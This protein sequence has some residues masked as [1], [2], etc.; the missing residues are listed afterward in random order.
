[1]QGV[2]PCPARSAGKKLAFTLKSERFS[3]FSLK[4][5][6]TLLGDSL[7]LQSWLSC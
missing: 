1:M 4:N 3:S 7:E 2:T 6:K 5:F